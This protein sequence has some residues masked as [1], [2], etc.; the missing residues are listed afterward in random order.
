MERKIVA[1]LFLFALLASPALS[2]AQEGSWERIEEDNG[3][4]FEYK[5]LK[6]TDGGS[7]VIQYRYGTRGNLT[8]IHTAGIPISQD[9]ESYV[10][11]LESSIYSRETNAPIVAKPQTPQERSA[12]KE[13]AQEKQSVLKGTP[14]YDYTITDSGTEWKVDIYAGSKEAGTVYTAEHYP[15]EDENGNPIYKYQVENFLEQKK[16]DYMKRYGVNYTARIRTP[17]FT[18]EYRVRDAGDKWILE[19]T[20]GSDET[21]RKTERAEYD[22]TYPKEEIENAG[23]RAK[24]N[25]LRSAGIEYE[26]KLKEVPQTVVARPSEEVKA[27]ELP[28]RLR[29]IA[30]SIVGGTT[31]DKTGNGAENE[32]TGIVQPPAVR[33]QTPVRYYLEYEITDGGDVWAVYVVY[34][35]SAYGSKMQRTEYPKSTTTYAYLHNAY[36]D[37]KANWL[38]QYGVS[39][40]PRYVD[41]TTVPPEE[42]LLPEI[43]APE[44]VP[45]LKSS[46]QAGIPGYVYEVAIIA[47]ILIV[48]AVVLSLVLGRGKGKKK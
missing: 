37:I 13:P 45:E 28:E 10:K 30:Q 4:Y 46:G 17:N 40:K 35:S 22:R 48:I 15:K 19:Y 1:L 20:Y 27:S 29:D 26:P 34:G 21:G 8:T 38:S 6:S 2:I 44:P 16:A 25:F 18:F 9:V 47:L 11:R 23:E 24:A 41:E 31:E 3:W 7:W 36:E 43:K 33:N 14:V 39:Y 12:P 32:T 42:P 5:V